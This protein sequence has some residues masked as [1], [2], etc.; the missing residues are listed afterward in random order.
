MLLVFAITKT[1]LNKLKLILFSQNHIRVT[2]AVSMLSDKKGSN[3]LCILMQIL[4]FSQY[5]A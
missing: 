5:F 1:T 4:K 3:Q 2:L